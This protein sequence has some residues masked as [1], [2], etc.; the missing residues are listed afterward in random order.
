MLVSAH[1]LRKKVGGEKMHHRGNGFIIPVIA[2]CISP[3]DEH[4]EV[5]FPVCK[6]ISHVPPLKWLIRGNLTR[7]ST[8]VVRETLAQ[9]ISFRR[10]QET[11]RSWTVGQEE[12]AASPDSNSKEAFQQ[13]N[14]RLC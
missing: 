10:C 1:L 13:K 11:R 6:R 12:V 2:N 5:D 3:V 7:R 14:P 8:S 4:R 9:E